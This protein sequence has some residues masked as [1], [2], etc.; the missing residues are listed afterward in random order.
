MSEINW[1]EMLGYLASLLTA[2]SLSMSSLVRLRWLNMVGS[3]CFGTY[4]VLLGSLPVALMNY[5]LVLMNIYY[6]WKIYTEKS[7]FSVLPASVS[8]QYVN[9][10]INLNKAEIKEFFPAFH[11]KED[12]EYSALMIH[13]DLALAGVFI[14]HRVDDNTM[15]VDLD[16]VLPQYRD[17]KPG[18][19]VFCENSG[20]FKEQGVSKIIS[21]KGSDSH[22]SYLSKIGFTQVNGRLEL[23]V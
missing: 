7:H 19:F 17:L 18:Q 13:R 20:F 6:L 21:A 14:C 23:S 10:F 1:P 2:V 8:D 15:E 16:F 5:Y 22:L 11:L 4:G 3:F 9:E 12:R